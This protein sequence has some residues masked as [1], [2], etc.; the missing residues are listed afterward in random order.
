MA[1]IL[2]L[3][4][5][6]EERGIEREATL[7]LRRPQRGRPFHLEELEALVSELPTSASCRRCR[8]D[9]DGWA[10]ETGLITDVLDR[11]EGDLA[12]VDAYLCGPPPMVDA[13]SRCSRPRAC[14]RRT[15]TSTSSRPPQTE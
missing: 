7:L 6:M 8:S 3:L 13:A 4:R 5:S 1:P 11:L 2:S 10:G 15:S 14:P 12:E 9:G